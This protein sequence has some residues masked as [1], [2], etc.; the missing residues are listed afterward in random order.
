M[1]NNIHPTAIIEGAVDLGE[2]NQI[3]AYSVLI[4]PLKLGNDNVVGPLVC[5]GT[6]GQDTKNPRYDSTSR[7]IEIGDS[8]I[9]REHTAIQK[10]ID[11]E[12]TRIGSRNYLMHSVHIPHDARISDDVTI[13]P[14]CALAGNAKLLSGAN[15]GLSVSVHQH[16][17]IGH[18]SM[19]AMGVAV[20][21]NVRPFAKLIPGKSLS[22]NVYAVK[23]FGFEEYAQEI[24]DYVERSVAPRSAPVKL[25]V[26]E[27][28][29]YHRASGR[30]LYE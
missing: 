2:S 19:V 7:R 12:V 13:T 28:E 9:I 10:P 23:K 22:V 4:G 16:S 29:A 15:L 25:L 24:A 26:D 14:M 18:Y 20:I 21:K 3:G 30:G 27:F 6:P 17:V 8:N 5:I 1:A 11:T